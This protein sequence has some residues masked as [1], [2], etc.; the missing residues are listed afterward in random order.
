MKLTKGRLVSNRAFV[1]AS[2]AEIKHRSVQGGLVGMVAQGIA[3]VVQMGS[4]LVLARLLSPTDFGLLGMVVAFTGVLNLFRDAGLS[5]AAVQRQELTHE[6][7]STL[8]WINVLIGVFL[9][10]VAAMASPFL[11]SF[12]REPRL[13]FVTIACATTFVVNGL[14]VQHRALLTREMRFAT[15]AKINILALVAGAIV[16]ITLAVS[17]YGY[18]ALVGTTVTHPLVTVIGVWITMPW[19]PGRPRRTAGIRGLLS[20]G[21]IVTLNSLVVYFAYNTEKVLL[22]RF[23]GAELLGLYGRAYQLANLPVEQLNSSFSAV[24]LAGLS[25]MQSDRERLRRSFLRGY[26]ILVSL[27]VP[28]VVICAVFAEEIVHILLGPQW[29]ESARVLRLLSPTVLA[30]TL[31]NPFG[32]FMQATGNV[33]RSLN[34]AL[35]IAPVV[36]GGIAFGLAHGPIG[37]ATGYSTA[38]LTLIV[39]VIVWATYNTGVR[40]ADCWNA[41]KWPLGAGA[42]AALAASLIK[43]TALAGFIP[44][45]VLV[46]GAAATFVVYACILLIG[47]DQRAMYR[48]LI[49]Q[50]LRRAP[51]PELAG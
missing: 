50:V 26:S 37:V 51:A 9:A 31:I 21:G 46:I 32:W 10:I 48:D 41:I 40:V 27:G 39:P 5:V 6:D 34:I 3:F 42:G 11:V 19:L 24:G 30:F 1:E 29:N 28:V 14:T 35:L 22:G 13:L 15:L 44:S 47:I 18:W 23:W 12:Y 45:A 33:R 36:I 4:T 43:V 17:G 2:V 20:T 38:M 25:R 7:A 16:G 49:G 8:F